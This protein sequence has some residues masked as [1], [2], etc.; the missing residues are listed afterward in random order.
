MSKTFTVRLNNDEQFIKDYADFKGVTVPQLLKEATIEHIE[1]L[2]DLQT[3]TVE[4]EKIE[5]GS[6]EL[7]S[8]EQFIDE[9]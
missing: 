1:D 2:I 6:S 4:L 7:I 5:N 8:W 3:A 9:Q